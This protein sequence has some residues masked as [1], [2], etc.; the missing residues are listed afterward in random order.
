[1]KCVN[2]LHDELQKD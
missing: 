1:M 2:Q